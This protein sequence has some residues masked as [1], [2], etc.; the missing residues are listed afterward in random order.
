MILFLL[1]F[2]YYTSVYHNLYQYGESSYGVTN[3]LLSTSRSSGDAEIL[4]MK[5]KE[6][7]GIKRFYFS[8]DS[9]PFGENERNY[10]V[11]LGDMRYLRGIEVGYSQSKDFN[12]NLRFGKMRDR[13]AYVFPTFKTN[14]FFSEAEVSVANHRFLLNSRWDKNRSFGTIG[15]QFDFE[16]GNLIILNDVKLGYADE[17]E[18]AIDENLIFRKENFS[19]RSLLRYY[20]YGFVGREGVEYSGGRFNWG[21][22][23]SLTLPFGMNVFS[24]F[25]QRGRLDEHLQNE[26]FDG[27]SYIFPF[28]LSV[29]FTNNFSWGENRRNGYR[30]YLTFSYLFSDKARLRFRYQNSYFN[31]WNERLQI[32]GVLNL[33]Y[34][35]VLELSASKSQQ[36][37]W[38]YSLNTFFKL[39]RYF[40]GRFRLNRSPS[41]DR[42]NYTASISMGGGSGGLSG[43]FALR[44]N[45]ETDSKVYTFEF[46]KRGAIRE[47]GFGTVTGR[48]WHDKNGDGIKQKSEPAMKDIEVLM[49]GENPAPIDDRGIYKFAPVSKGKH[50]IKL[51]IKGVPAFLGGDSLEKK[52]KT[53]VLDFKVVNFPIF[54][55][56]SISGIVY[57]DKNHNY[58]RDENEEGVPNVRVSINREG[59]SRH[60]YTNYHGKYSISNIVPGDYTVQASR[61]PPGYD[62]SPR[63]FVLYLD[64]TAGAEREGLNFGIAKPV[65]KIDRKEF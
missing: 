56:S 16:I 55:L 47:V 31:S 18:V 1:S 42:L 13:V 49:D 64:L 23:P 6:D 3:W 9:I 53:G 44:G 35:N 59:Y 37:G 57:Y 52:I 29:D 65:K 10:H 58:R 54:S 50:T 51:N 33:P 34:S 21:I 19:I 60:T 41:L 43:R 5:Y 12:L 24:G 14:D 38:D 45:S 7:Y 39:G 4:L 2:N 27:F 17:P 62:L 63:G 30:N 46:I 32:E 36:Y 15:D 48:V 8:Y 61:F 11:V 28:N 26:V 40:N 20:S 22:N 25:Y